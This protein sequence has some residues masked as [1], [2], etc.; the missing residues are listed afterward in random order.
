MRRAQAVPE[1]WNSHF[2]TRS[3]YPQGL[4][5]VLLSSVELEPGQAHWEG[6]VKW[7]FIACCLF[8]PDL[9]LEHGSRCAELGFLLLSTSDVVRKE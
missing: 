6:F 2:G 3:L 7:T 9:S 4:C 8:L 5:P 1:G